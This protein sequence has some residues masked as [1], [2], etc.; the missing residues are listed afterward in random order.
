MRLNG[1]AEKSS[2]GFAAHP[3]R[4]VTPSNYSGGR[5]LGDFPNI[6]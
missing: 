4:V 3:L 5:V 2:N 6:L 1:G